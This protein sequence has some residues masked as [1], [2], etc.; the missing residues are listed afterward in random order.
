MI[1]THIKQDQREYTL[2]TDSSLLRVNLQTLRDQLGRNSLTITLHFKAL[3]GQSG[4]VRVFQ[5]KR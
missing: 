1:I 2:C 3:I 4:T 5:N